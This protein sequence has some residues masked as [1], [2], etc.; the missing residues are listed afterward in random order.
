MVLGLTWDLNFLIKKKRFPLVFVWKENFEG[1]GIFWGKK[2][3]Y[4]HV[5][6]LCNRF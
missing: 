6:N 1:P 5:E 2:I 3:Q 4:V